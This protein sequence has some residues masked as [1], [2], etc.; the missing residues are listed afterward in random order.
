VVETIQW[1]PISSTVRYKRLNTYEAIAI[2]QCEERGEYKVR[3]RLYG[4]T[5]DWY[6]EDLS[7]AEEKYDRLTKCFP[8]K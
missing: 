5:K 7:C 2:M 4:Y 3:L 6:F 8:I 1:I